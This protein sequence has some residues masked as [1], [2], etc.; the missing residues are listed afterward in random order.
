MIKILN[1]KILLLVLIAT[2]I[3]GLGCNQ[4]GQSFGS[5]RNIVVLADS[6]LWEQVGHSLTKALSI[7]KY[8][9][10]PEM[11]FILNRVNPGSIG[12]LKKYPQILLVGTLDQQGVTKSLL[13]QLLPSG[14]KGRQLV[15]N[16]ER[17]FFPVKNPWSREQLLG[18]VVSKDLPTL[19]ENLEVNKKLI[20]EAFDD[21]VNDRVF[22]Q[23]YFSSE[24]KE[25]EKEL[26][27][28][29]GWSIRVPHDFMMV[30]DSSE[31]RFTWLSRRGPKRLLRDVSVY[32]EPVDDPS[33]LSKEW[34]LAARGKN[35]KGFNEGYFIHT[36]SKI[37]VEEE[38]VNFQGRY[39]IKLD[40][41]WQDNEGGGP[42][43]SYAFYNESDG[44][45]YL[46]D[47][48]VWAPEQRKW[49][50]IRQLDI[51]LHTFKT[52]ADLKNKE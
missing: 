41:I 14:S 11:I 3:I 15:E 38:L 6:L 48:Y 17:F 19:T 26:M 1:F 46:L 35:L 9:P 12:N 30:V 44:R 29:H 43:R 5:L 40:G 32:W 22:K 52:K 37:Q 8:T 28:K 18:V 50:Y 23:V 49:P 39:A 31:S 25:I 24:Q 20:F 27:S 21:H 33:I 13:D 36:D 10:Q 45:L 16:N 47:G 42:F 4:K 2:M 51:I 7:D 34:M